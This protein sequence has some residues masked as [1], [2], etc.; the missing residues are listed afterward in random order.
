MPDEFEKWEINGFNAIEEIK[1][2]LTV[3]DEF[4]KIAKIS[5]V[6]IQ[7]YMPEDMTSVEINIILLLESFFKSTWTMRN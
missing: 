4:N 7:S 6:S 1:N 3:W 2:T 5:N